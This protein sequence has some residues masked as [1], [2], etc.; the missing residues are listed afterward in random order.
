MRAGKLDRTITIER[1]G[2]T[3]D[4]YGV[5]SEGWAPVATVRA[6][7]VQASTEEA[8]RAYGAATE[9]LTIF[10]TRFVEGVTPADRITYDGRPHNIVEL[11]EIGRR[12]GLEIRTVARGP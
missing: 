10:R 6:Q 1:A 12:R 3:L 5:P 11:K 2:E 8:I 4:E 7:L 9:V